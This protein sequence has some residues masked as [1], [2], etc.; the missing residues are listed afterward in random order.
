MD[1]NCGTYATFATAADGSVYAWGLNNYGQLA[2]PG[3]APV[4]APAAVKALKAHAVQ[5]VR[6]G[7]HH[8]LVIADGGKLFSFGRPT[9]GRLGQRNAD[10]AADASC[11]EVKPVDGL[12][13]VS[14]VAAAAGLAVSGKRHSH[15]AA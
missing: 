15:S 3:Q 4:Y 13:G 9:Y 5:A 6:S 11:P 2:L 10:I 8:T 14:V 7:Q 1:V 12:E